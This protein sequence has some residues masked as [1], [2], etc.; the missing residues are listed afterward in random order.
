MA[1]QSKST[2]WEELEKAAYLAHIQKLEKNINHWIERFDYEN[3]QWSSQHDI[4]AWHAQ[5]EVRELDQKIIALRAELE[6]LELAKLS[7]QKAMRKFKRQDAKLRPQTRSRPKIDP[8]RQQVARKFTSL[9][10]ASLMQVV[11]AKSV[12]ELQTLIPGSSKMNWGRWKSQKSTPTPN[13]L[14]KLL[15]GVHHGKQLI[16]L[17]TNPLPQELLKLIISASSMKIVFREDSQ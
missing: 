1:D 17:P 5:C 7:A 10:V 12:S 11:G 14:T 6:K 9:W 15:S 4:D 8:E 2:K 13:H 3:N 16:D